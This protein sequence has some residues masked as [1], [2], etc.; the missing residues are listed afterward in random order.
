M[1]RIR[2]NKLN[3]DDA[4]RQLLSSVVRRKRTFE[5]PRPLLWPL[6]NLHSVPRSFYM[7]CYCPHND[8]VFTGHNQP[9]LRGDA[10]IH[11]AI[12]GNLGATMQ[13]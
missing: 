7:K 11:L 10:A 12:R 6:H 2:S 5:L 3:L 8:E 4:A 13:G 9:H 1:V